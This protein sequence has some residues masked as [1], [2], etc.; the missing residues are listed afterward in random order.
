MA[1]KRDSGP[2]KDPLLFKDAIV[3]KSSG[4]PADTMVPLKGGDLGDFGLSIGVKI[5]GEPSTLLDELSTLGK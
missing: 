3:P 5:G 1:I 4:K 2:V